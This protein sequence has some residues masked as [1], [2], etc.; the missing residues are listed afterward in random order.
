MIRSIYCFHVVFETWKILNNLGVSLP[1]V[2]E[3]NPFK[4]EYDLEKYRK[5]CDDFEVEASD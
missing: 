3:F 4:S 5:L 1:Y 2:D